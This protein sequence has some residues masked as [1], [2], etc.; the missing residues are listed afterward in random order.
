MVDGQMELEAQ[1]P[2]QGGATTP[3]QSSEDPVAADGCI[4]AECQL[5]AVSRVDAVLL[6]AER[7]KE[8]V[9]RQQQVRQQALTGESAKRAG[10]RV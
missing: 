7:V 6:A 2:A 10:V 3:G 9:K 4:V 1:E 5:G 8:P